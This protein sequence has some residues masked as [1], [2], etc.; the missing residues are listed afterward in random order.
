MWTTE[1][2]H[3][4]PPLFLNCVWVWVTGSLASDGVNTFF[5]LHSRMS[6]T[7]TE[8]ASSAGAGNYTNQNLIQFRD[9][10]LLAPSL[11]SWNN[12]KGLENGIKKM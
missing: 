6:S 2:C 12:G 9:I 10:F 5:F 1:K 4:P 3:V 11:R 8:E 7:A